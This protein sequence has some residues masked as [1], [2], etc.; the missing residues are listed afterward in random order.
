MTGLLT[1]TEA[2]METLKEAETEMETETVATDPLVLSHWKR[3]V[4]MMQTDF[5][6]VRLEEESTWQTVVLIP[7][8]GGDYDT[9]GL[10]EVVWN[11]VTVILN[12]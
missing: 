7:K 10:A 12:F 1:I 11:V 2:D 4:V 5:R 3:V 6:E 8:E 9:I